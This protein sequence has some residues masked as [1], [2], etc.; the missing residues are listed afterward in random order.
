MKADEGK[1]TGDVSEAD[2][3]ARERLRK[4]SG[5]NLRLNRNIKHDKTNKHDRSG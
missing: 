5:I 1:N 2:G 4:N 3:R